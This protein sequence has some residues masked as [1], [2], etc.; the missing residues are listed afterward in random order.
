M[1]VCLI[2]CTART[3]WKKAGCLT[4]SQSNLSYIILL[5]DLGVAIEHAVQL[6]S[7]RR[8]KKVQKGFKNI[9]ECSRSFK[10]LGK[11]QVSKRRFIKVYEGSSRFM[12]F[13]D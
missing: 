12:N 6:G 7:S 8:F 10:I 1:V 4:E 2:L 11:V 3:V 9:K 5:L 13:S